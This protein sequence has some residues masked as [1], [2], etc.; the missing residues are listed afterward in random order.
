MR[1]PQTPCDKV[2]WILGSSCGEMSISRLRQQTGLT[3]A[4]LDI[5]LGGLERGE[6]DSNKASIGNTEE[7]I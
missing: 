3:K 7:L 6:F 5:V 1:H 4:G 2:L